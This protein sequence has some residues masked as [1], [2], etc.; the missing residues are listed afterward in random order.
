M[1][2]RRA[3]APRLINWTGERCVPWAPD[4]QVIYEHYHRYLWAQSLVTGNRVLDLGSGEGFG[5]ALLADTARAVVGMDIDARTV[6]HSRL[7]YDADNLEFRTGS[8]TDLSDFPDDAFDVVVAFEVIEHVRDQERMLTEVRRVLVDAGLFVVSTP[9]R[10]TYSE[11]AGYVN[12]FHEHE[13]TQEELTALLRERFSSLA[14]FSQAVATGSRID[15]LG[16]PES[17]L[18]LAVAIERVGDE[19]LTVGPPPPRYLIAIASDSPLPDL[20]GQSTL[21][22][23]GLGLLR[24]A[25]DAVL[26]ER[27]RARVGLEA[28]ERRIRH[29][30][31]RLTGDVIAPSRE[32]DDVRGIV[33]DVLQEL[34]EARQE[35]IRVE[36]SVTWQLFQRAR[37]R[38]YGAIGHES[39]AGRRLRTVLQ[40][41]GRLTADGPTRGQVGVPAQPAMTVPRFAVPE[42]SIIIPV[43]SDP[44]LTERCLR[45]VLHS[46]DGV[47]Y[48]VVAVD[49]DADAATKALLGVVEGI[50]VVHAE[51]LGFRRSVDRGVAE[52]RGRHVIVLKNDAEPRPGW[53]HSMVER[54]ESTEDAGIVTGK[55]VYPDGSLAEA[56]GIVWQEGELWSY[57]RGG[58]PAAPEYNYVREVDYGSAAA[59]LVRSEVWRSAGGFDES[60]LTGKFEDADLCFTARALGWR[61]WYEPRA[62]VLCASDA[63]TGGGMSKD[64]NHDE[65]L[66][67]QKFVVKWRKALGNQLPHPSQERAHLAS[68][69]RR[70][71][72]VLVVDQTVPAPDRDPS[73]LRMWRI[74]EGLV[75]LGCQVTFLPDDREA[76]E[77]YAW[78]L[79]GMGVELLHGR[80]DLEQRV[81]DLEPRLQ[82]AVLSRPHVAARY[83]HLVR[84]H[85]PGAL[86]AYDTVNLRFLHEQ[87]RARHGGAVDPRAVE[88]LRQVELA[89]AR[90]SDV[91]LVVSAGERDQL[92]AIAPEVAVEVVPDAHQIVA[93]VLGPE[94]RSGLLFVGHF[95]DARSIDAAVRLAREVMPRVWRE[96]DDVTLTVVGGDPP[97]EVRALASASIKIVGAVEDLTPML[98]ASM[99]ML[100]PVDHRAEMERSV[101][102]SLAAGLPVVTSTLSAEDPDVAEVPAPLGADDPDAFADRIV[103]LHRD[104]DAWRELSAKGQA[105]AERLCSPIAQRAALSRLLEM[106]PGA[107]L[108]ESIPAGR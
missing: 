63:T 46:S 78:R 80:V 23:F 40:R 9:E 11:A 96:I 39:P 84:E 7:N 104:A 106:G 30:R 70:G 17:G 35:L 56:G 1:P 97:P 54:A 101:A 51:N 98:Q 60:F 33:R 99:A 88:G 48:E 49:D 89:L 93:R 20:P 32:L 44:S 94:D 107:K 41:I 92:V 37:S 36:Q 95:K 28:M 58:D 91:A 6:E 42:V 2:S 73:S 16:R 22:D 74:L 10:R 81:A 90:S 53:L 61:V 47:P 45:A 86:L 105:H 13:L 87:R 82:L 62:V 8:A 31:R 15:S 38:L 79:R 67:Q 21:S 65:R 3:G 83:M 18:Y 100:A 34:E 4:V 103:R 5:A 24:E 66:S 12:P 77:P 55:L 75:T 76:L 27:E 68:D 19:W 85:A 71:P 64:G 57:G 26:E 52:A 43:H 25:E 14:L 50:R 108:G 69:R 72:H 102:Q 29:E 59:L